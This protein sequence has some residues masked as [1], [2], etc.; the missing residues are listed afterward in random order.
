[1]VNEDK[2]KGAL[3]VEFSCERL[4]KLRD[5]LRGRSAQEGD[6]VAEARVS[7]DAFGDILARRGC[8]KSE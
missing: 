4:L 3:R 8:Q 1:M 2:I 6:L 7:R 5:H